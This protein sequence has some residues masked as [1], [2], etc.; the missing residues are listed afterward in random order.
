MQDGHAPRAP[1]ASSARIWNRAAMAR[2]N[3]RL[4]AA[5]VSLGAGDIIELAS[6]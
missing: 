1:G 4:G 6:I 3:Q 2:Q 5:Q